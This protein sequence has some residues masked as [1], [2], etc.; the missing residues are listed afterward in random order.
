MG[1][2]P[3][4]HKAQVRSSEPEIFFEDVQGERSELSVTTDRKDV[5]QIVLLSMAWDEVGMLK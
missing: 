3:S 2:L 1:C 5:S 4:M